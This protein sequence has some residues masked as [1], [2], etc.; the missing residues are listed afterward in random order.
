MNK[1]FCQNM[2]TQLPVP[3]QTYT[4]ADAQKWV[5]EQ[6][7][8]ILDPQNAMPHTCSKESLE[9]HCPLRGDVLLPGVHTLGVLGGGQLGR[10]FLMAAK[11]RGYSTVLWTP[12][13]TPPAKGLSD[14]VIH[15]P[16]DDEAALAEFAKTVD[17]VTV[18]FEAVPIPTILALESLG[19]RVRPSS[20]AIAVCQNRALER[21]F[22]VANGIAVSPHVVVH[23]KRELETAFL[24]LGEQ[25]CIVKTT[26][27]GYDGKGQRRISTLDELKQ[28]WKDLDA[29]P[30]APLLVEHV[31]PFKR[32]VSILM[33]RGIDGSRRN[34]PLVENQHVNG[35]LNMSFMP[36]PETQGHTLLQAEDIAKRLV[37]ALNYVGILCVEFF[38]LEDGSLLVNELAPR[39]H[40]S[41]HFTIEACHVSQYQQ[42]VNALTGMPLGNA[43]MHVK[44]VG[45]MNLLSN[46]WSKEGASPN[47]QELLSRYPRLSVHLYGKKELRPNRKMGHI[48]LTKK[49]TSMVE[50]AFDE[51]NSMLT[52][53]D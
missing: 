8:T 42:Q 48:T 47:W 44:A 52:T 43:E 41:G 25:A 32:E 13:K 26:R 9:L 38:E 49:D 2:M 16:F 11:Q 5:D 46:R 22:L 40:N 4:Q 36:A 28:A 18:E 35:V 3:T 17:A 19:C 23:H 12:E 21:A 20:K 6:F 30:E 37:K 14:K 29:S 7:A 39:P 10:Y 51:I 34:Y 15:A 27:F 24:T 1:V 53:Y 33:A 31:I 45:L 50:S